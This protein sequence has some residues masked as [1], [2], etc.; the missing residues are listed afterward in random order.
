VRNRSAMPSV[1]SPRGDVL[2][3]GQVRPRRF[4]CGQLSGPDKGRPSGSGP[5]AQRDAARARISFGQ[6]TGDNQY[7][8]NIQIAD[9]N[10]LNATLA[11][12]AWKTMTGFYH[13][14]GRTPFSTYAID[15][16]TLINE[17]SA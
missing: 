1:S 6:G 10:A 9:L 16:R 7:G 15:T 4:L 11:V 5:P 2:P 14:L 3:D 17:G 8:T 12:I 13:D